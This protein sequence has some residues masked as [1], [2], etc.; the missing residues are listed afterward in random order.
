MLR[1]RDYLEMLYSAAASPYGVIVESSDR[2]KLS[3]RLN[4]ARR[5][6]P[7]LKSIAIVLHPLNPDQLLLVKRNPDAEERGP[8]PSEGDSEPREG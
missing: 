8:T 1:P 2:A 5:E 6:D 7:A 4:L 3:A